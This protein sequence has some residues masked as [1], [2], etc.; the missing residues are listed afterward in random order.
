V[1]FRV[2]ELPPCQADPVLLKQVYANLI[3]NAMKFSRKREPPVVEIGSFTRDG[4]LIFFVRDNGI[5]FD[6]RYAEKI[7]GVFERLHNAD[8]YEGTGVGLAI[9]QRIIEIHGGH[10]WVESEVDKGT[11]FYF[12][13]W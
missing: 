2:G 1:E 9:V 6:M 3:S 10:I 13:C 4:H 5:G 11:T 12:T 7:F 8:E